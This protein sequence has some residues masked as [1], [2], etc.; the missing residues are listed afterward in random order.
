[1]NLRPAELACYLM[2]EVVSCGSIEQGPSL[3]QTL[4]VLLQVFWAR[5]FQSNSSEYCNS[6]GKDIFKVNICRIIANKL[7]LFLVLLE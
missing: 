4:V 6:I 1:M 3:G 2:E 5:E 7:P